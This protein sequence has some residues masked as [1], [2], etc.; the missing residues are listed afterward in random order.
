[1]YA[2]ITEYED[3]VAVGLPLNCFVEAFCR[4]ALVL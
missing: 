1:M 3:V 2:V 4:I